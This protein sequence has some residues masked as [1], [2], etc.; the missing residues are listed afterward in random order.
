MT[1]F[2]GLRSKMYSVHV[3]VV[4]HMREAKGVKASTVMYTIEF[5]DHVKCL[6]ENATQERQQHNFRSKLREIQ[7]NKLA[8]S[9]LDDKRLIL[10]NLTDT[11]PWGHYKIPNVVEK[12]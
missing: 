8:S 5:G 11:L 2:V 6:H 7:K 12:N 3:N 1:E 4:D 9:P 10:G